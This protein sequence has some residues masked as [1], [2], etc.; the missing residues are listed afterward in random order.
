MTATAVMSLSTDPPALALAV[1]RSASLNPALAHG[2]SLVV[3]LL[4]EDQAELARAFAGGLQ[5]EERF[6][7]GGWSSDS[8]GGPVLE[9]A[10]ASLSGVVD[11]KVE[12]STHTLLVVGVREVRVSPGSQP[13]LYA[14][15]DFT[16][17]RE[18]ARY[19]A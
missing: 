4:C 7:L 3:Q 5:P 14:H 1:N 8:W 12:L 6:Q 9:G 10:S 17:L 19:A 18:P 2:A 15:G 16:G 13:L 11:Q